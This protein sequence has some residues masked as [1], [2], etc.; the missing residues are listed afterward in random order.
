MAPYSKLPSV[1]AN[2]LVADGELGM[3]KTLDVRGVPADLIIGLCAVI[4][5]R[6]RSAERS[7]ATST[8]A[9]GLVPGLG[10]LSVK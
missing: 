8:G 9:Y 5:M 10:R 4:S 1:T 3:V 7:I 6:P 2:P